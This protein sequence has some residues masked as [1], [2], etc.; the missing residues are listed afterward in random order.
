MV[1]YG[2]VLLQNKILRIDKSGPC[3]ACATVQIQQGPLLYTDHLSML[4][5]KGDGEGTADGEA[6]AEARWMIV[7]KTF[8][9]S[10]IE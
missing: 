10:A 6:E 7:H 1:C 3:S 8:V 9:P 4:L 5:I 2:M